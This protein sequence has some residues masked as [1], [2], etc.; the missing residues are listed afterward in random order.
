M[1]SRRSDKFLSEE[2]LDL[3]GMTMEELI[4]WWQ[5]WLEQSQSTNDEDRDEYSHGVFRRQ[6]RIKSRA[7]I[8]PPAPS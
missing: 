8:N 2:D 4:A 7:R 6:P 1:I 3:R 5:L